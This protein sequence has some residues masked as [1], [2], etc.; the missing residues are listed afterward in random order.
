MGV[1]LSH[2]VHIEDLLGCGL[3]SQTVHVEKTLVYMKQYGNPEAVS[4]SGVF[5]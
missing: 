1:H 3:I 4:T 5:R 2:L